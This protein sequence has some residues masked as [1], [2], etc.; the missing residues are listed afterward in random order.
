M[1][2]VCRIVLFLLLVNGIPPLVAMAAGKRFDTAIDFGLQWFDGRP[3]FGANKSIR[4]LLAA[5]LGGIAAFPLL[6]AHWWVA[7]LA[8]LA[9]ML[10]DLTSS[11]IKRRLALESGEEIIGLDQLPESLLPLL[12]LNRFL[13][14]EFAQNLLVLVLF[15]IISW[16]CSR[17]WIHL[18]TRPQPKEQQVVRS[19]VRSRE[20]RA[21][22][23]PYAKYHVWLNL[24]SFLTDQVFLTFFFKAIGLYPKGKKNAL[25]LQVEKHDFYFADLPAS[26]DGLR[27]L[28]LADLHL[29]GLA[30]LTTKLKEVLKTIKVDLCLIGG[31]FRMK[32][33]GPT[34]ECVREIT[35]LTPHIQAEAGMFGVLGN[36]DC[37]EMLPELEDAGVVMLV[38]DSWALKKNGET[39]W[40]MGVD[41]PHYYRLHDAGK[42][43]ELVPEG[44]FAVFLA[45]SPEAFLDAAGVNA[46]LYLCGHTHGGQICLRQAVPIITNSRAPRFTASG[47][48]RYSNM[49]GYTSRGVGPSS[50][51]VRYNC[52]GEVTVITL[53]RS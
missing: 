40:L 45:H 41:D 52:P 10:G 30:G 38:N 36:H 17:V 2:E 44:G 20:W 35:K 3:I 18:T 15:I 13:V 23:T 48:W 33:Y 9:A 11:F 51:P 16:M 42:A 8:A 22:H 37:L 39:L 29:D 26:F 31:D 47:K 6:G 53:R 32:T 1:T 46:N 7:G 34:E 14:L 25:E 50:I 4:G 12:L 28:W 27:L 21:C 49:Q 24:S 43:A 5:T 19:R